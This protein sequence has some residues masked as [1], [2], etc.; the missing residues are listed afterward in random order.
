MP[1]DRNRRNDRPATGNRTGG[2]RSEQK[3]SRQS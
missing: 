1:Y 2:G 3:R